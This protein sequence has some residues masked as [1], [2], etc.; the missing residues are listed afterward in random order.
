[1]QDTNVTTRAIF[2]REVS[3]KLH[4]SGIY[5]LNGCA[6]EQLACVQYAGY[7]VSDLRITNSQYPFPPCAVSLTKLRRLAPLQTRECTDPEGARHT[8][9]IISMACSLALIQDLCTLHRLIF[10][11]A[12]HFN[13]V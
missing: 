7:A 10:F 13:V 8:A 9:I 5:S 3:Y 2:S 1:M 11:L 12:P 4:I 6:C